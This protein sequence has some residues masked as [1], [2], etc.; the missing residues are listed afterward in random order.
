MSFVPPS[1]AL[2]AAKLALGAAQSVMGAVKDALTPNQTKARKTAEEFETMFLE[3][4]MSQ[5]FPQEAG[6][7]PAGDNGTGGQIYRVM[8]VN[9]HAKAVAKSG[10]IGIADQIY[11]QL[12][13]MQSQ[14]GSR[15]G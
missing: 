1:L 12:I 13:Q 7:G 5:V 15:R 2:P 14:E 3:N 8:L 11:R 10:G 4:M 9:E 6:E